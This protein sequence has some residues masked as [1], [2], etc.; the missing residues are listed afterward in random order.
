MDTMDEQYL[1]EQGHEYSITSVENWE[2]YTET[3][4]NKYLND[5][6]LE[7]VKI[8]I[9]KKLM[10]SKINVV[11]AWEGGDLETQI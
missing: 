5:I 1:K 4:D 2:K 8:I 9:R 10:R 3:G 7:G 6:D 11:I